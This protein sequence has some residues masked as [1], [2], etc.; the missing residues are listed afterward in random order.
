M[1]INGGT[2]NNEI[3]GGLGDDEIFANAGDVLNGNANTPI[4]IGCDQNDSTGEWLPFHD[5]GDTL[6]LSLL[7]GG[8][9]IVMLEDGSITIT[10]VPAIVAVDF[11]NIVGSAGNDT[12][13]GNSLPNYINGGPGND[14]IDGM[15]GDD[16][17]VGGDGDDTLAGGLGDDC[18][19]GNAGNDLL[20]ESAPL[21]ADGTP[22]YGAVRQR[23]GRARRRPGSRRH[24]ELRSSHQPHGRLPRHHQLVQRR[25]RS[26]RGRVSDECDDVFFTTENAITGSGNDILSADFLNNQSDNEFTAGAATTRSTAVPATTS[27]IRARRRTAPTS[28]RG[29]PARDTADYSGRSNGVNVSLDGAGNDGETG[30]GDNIDGRVLALGIAGVCG[31]DNSFWNGGEEPFARTRPTT[32]LSLTTRSRTCRAARV[33]TS[34]PVTTSATSS[35]PTAATTPS[36]VAAALTTCRAA[37]GTTSSPATSATT[38]STAAQAPTGVTGRPLV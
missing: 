37:T 17:L 2:G 15:G 1:V 19:V 28:S 22:N 4:D 25:C 38:H 21:K 12:I 18:V 8:F 36:P 16:V 34:C 35:Q 31:E 32:T 13:T 5:G 24:R 30:E 26:E 6:N 7:A 29:T 33:T 23:R 11:E 3:E 10:P 20:N 14:T 9:T 27:S